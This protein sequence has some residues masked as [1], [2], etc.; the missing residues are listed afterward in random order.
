MQAYHQGWDTMLSFEE[1]TVRA[2]SL[3]NMTGGL[4][5]PPYN[6]SL[7]HDTH[8][9]KS[10]R[11]LSD[12]GKLK[13]TNTVLESSWSSSWRSFHTA[14]V[15]LWHLIVHRC[16]RSDDGEPDS[17]LPNDN[18]LL[19]CDLWWSTSTP[20][21]FTKL[22]A[23]HACARIEPT[24]IYSIIRCHCLGTPPLVSHREPSGVFVSS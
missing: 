18:L 8:S 15:W 20:V 14:Q 16:N 19:I 12:T 4:K 2:L 9:H 22:I 13:H 10:V 11:S 6:C 7:S 24:F 21:A 1:D 3:H 5:T 23:L 17:G